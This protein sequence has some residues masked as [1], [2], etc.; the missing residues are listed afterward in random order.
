MAAEV[1][2]DTSG[3]FALLNAD[4]P[5]HTA[6]RELLREQQGKRHRSVTTSWVVGETCT[7]L[8]ARK[9]PHMVARFLDH[10]QASKA[11]GCVH[12]DESH[13]DQTA[14]FLRKHLDQGYSFVDCSSM[15]IMKEMRIRS[16]FTTDHH[17]FEAG[18]ETPP[19]AKGVKP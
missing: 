2:W 6:V 15:V 11:L 9:R 18:F 1:F 5:V 4:D 16:V 17:F 14:A 7:L 8:V 3:F 12:P 19:P 13:F 10:V